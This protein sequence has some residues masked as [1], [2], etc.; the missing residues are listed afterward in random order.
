MV[1]FALSFG[2]KKFAFAS[3]STSICSCRTKTEWHLHTDLHF[4]ALVFPDASLSFVFLAPKRKKIEGC[5]HTACLRGVIHHYNKKESHNE[6]IQKDLFSCVHY[7]NFN[8]SCS[9][10]GAIRVPPKLAVIQ[11]FSHN[12]VHTLETVSHCQ[13]T[14]FP[15]RLKIKRNSLLTLL[16]KQFRLI[17]LGWHQNWTSLVS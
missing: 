13:E 16:I 8:F 7:F 12:Q 4:T 1:S 15:H 11:C 17:L 2:G 14:F 9:H 10:P 6:Y 5:W 3:P